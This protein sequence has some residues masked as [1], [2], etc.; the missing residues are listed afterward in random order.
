MRRGARVVGRPQPVVHRS[1]AG[2]AQRDL[3][4]QLLRR[5][6]DDDAGERDLVPGHL[7]VDA[8][9]VTAELLEQRQPDRDGDAR[10]GKI[11]GKAGGRRRCRGR[12]PVASLA[13]GG[14]EER[15]AGAG[16]EDCQPRTEAATGGV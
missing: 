15:R 14:A 9:A 4:G 1:H 13:G 12:G 5:P 2:H 11:A 3:L 8:Q 10:G 16:Q 6:A 7:D